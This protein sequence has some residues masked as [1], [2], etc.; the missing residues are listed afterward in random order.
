MSGIHHLARG[1]EAMP[2]KLQK[3]GANIWYETQLP[4]EV[5]LRMP[6]KQLI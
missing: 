5:R 2:Q 4:P 1:Y 6:A 3:L